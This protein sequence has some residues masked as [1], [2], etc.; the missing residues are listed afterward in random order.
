[1][2]A[3]LL[4][5]TSSCGS[6]KII[7][8]TGTQENTVIQQ[9]EKPMVA[10]PAQDGKNAFFYHSQ[11]ERVILPTDFEVTKTIADLE[12]MP[13]KIEYSCAYN[14][15]DTEAGRTN[16]ISYATYQA[17]KINGNADV[18]VEPK[19]EIN[20]EK[21]RI[22]SV[23][24]SGYAAHYRNFRTATPQDLKLLKESKGNSCVVTKKPQQ[25]TPE[26]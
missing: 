17:L 20:S 14:E 1:M 7:Q 24:V 16:A 5:A 2:C 4:I 22:T 26:E 15:D 11:D 12:V 21:G 19:H 3:M 10:S 18:L 25:A 8:F 23:K 6:K 9:E 13:T